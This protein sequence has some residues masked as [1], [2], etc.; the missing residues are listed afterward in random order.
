[1]KQL[2]QLLGISLFV[3]ALLILSTK[4]IVPPPSNGK[5]MYSMYII[6]VS[7]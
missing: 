7:I 6:G 1:M 5:K 4:L 2:M 3:G